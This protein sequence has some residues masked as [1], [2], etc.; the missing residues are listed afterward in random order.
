MS[1][2]IG[3]KGVFCYVVC[4]IK[5]WTVTAAGRNVLLHTHAAQHHAHL[6]LCISFLFLAPSL[7]VCSWR[8]CCLPRHAAPLKEQHRPILATHGRAKRQGQR[9]TNNNQLHSAWHTDSS[10]RGSGRDWEQERQ[11]LQQSSFHMAAILVI[12]ASLRLK[13][14]G[15]DLLD[16]HCSCYTLLMYCGW[17]WWGL[18]SSQRTYCLQMEVLCC[19]SQT[20][21]YYHLWRESNSTVIKSYKYLL[22]QNQ[23]MKNNCD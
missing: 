5:S 2:L 9:T 8:P 14:V 11:I 3:E 12:S 18:L 7:N 4:T 19:Y 1:C 22:G 16:L 17:S 13:A 15:G 21:S 10:Y 6:H 20:P 23:S